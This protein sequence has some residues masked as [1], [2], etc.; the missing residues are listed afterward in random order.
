MTLLIAAPALAGA[1]EEDLPPGLRDLAKE[2]GWTYMGSGVVKGSLVYQ[3]KDSKGTHYVSQE[4]LEYEKSK[5]KHNDEEG[6]ISGTPHTIAHRMFLAAWTVYQ[7]FCTF[8]QLCTDIQ[9]LIQQYQ[10]WMGEM[11]EPDEY[12]PIVC[13]IINGQTNW[14]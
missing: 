7:T 14:R 3:F 13:D 9:W 11:R 6:V 12:G 10:L 4:W 2:Q 1:K 5:E 8:R